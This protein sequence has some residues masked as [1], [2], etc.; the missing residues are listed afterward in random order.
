VDAPLVREAF[1]RELDAI[2]AQV[3]SEEHAA[4]RRAAA[5]AREVFLEAGMR[6]FLSLA[7]DLE[8]G[9]R[10]RGTPLSATPA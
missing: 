1:A 8:P 4:Y 5:D 2:L 10:V 7:S 9:S 3:P 6:P